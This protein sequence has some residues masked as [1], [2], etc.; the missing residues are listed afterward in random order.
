MKQRDRT[1]MNSEE[2]HLSP[3]QS[4]ATFRLPSG[5]TDIKSAPKWLTKTV[6]TQAHSVQWKRPVHT[7]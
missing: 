5:E 7:S 2:E 3:E 4:E 6:P 1:E